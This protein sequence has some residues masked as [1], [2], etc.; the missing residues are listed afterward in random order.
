MLSRV[1]DAF[2]WMGRYLERAEHSARVLDVYLGLTLDDPTD[3]VGRT[4]LAGLGS[5]SAVSTPAPK[6][7]ADPD[8]T[9]IDPRHLAAIM[10]SVVAARENARQIREQISSEMWEQVNRTYLE[11][12]EAG[13]VSTDALDPGPL[14]RA[15]VDGSHLFKGVTSGTLSRDEGWHFI[16]LGRH[17]ERAST[18]SSML[19]VCFADE[20]LAHVEA[21]RAPSPADF[22]GLLRA[23]AAFEAYCR[24]YTADFRAE[25][26]AEFLLLN[27]ECPRSVRFDVD[28]IE[29]S[30]A[31]IARSLGRQA[32]SRPDRFAGRLRAKLSF[33]QIDEIMAESL[34][35]YVQSVHRQCD[36]VHAALYQ[37]YITYPIES[38]IQP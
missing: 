4:L 27:A 18:T 12:R 19:E 36:L 21:E 23:C 24:F 5:A 8:T 30:L 25:R 32:T 3:M 10:S 29:E 13:R 37:T 1:A 11:V 2:Y 33:S 16:Q 28:R 17:I 22:A 7:P 38:A 26:L 6:T 35:A 14:L 9:R 15:V 20:E 34:I 31:A